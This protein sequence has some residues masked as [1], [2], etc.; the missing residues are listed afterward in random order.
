MRRFWIVPAIVVF[1]LAGAYRPGS[2]S[3]SASGHPHAVAAKKHF[4]QVSAGGNLPGDHTCGLRTDH[5]LACWGNNNHGH[6]PFRLT[7]GV[8]R[9]SHLRNRPPP[10]AP[11]AVP[12]AQPARLRPTI[13]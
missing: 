4:L 13:G 9:S 2:V 7:H 10:I 5:T 12:M 3:V 1:V 11:R 8:A 6:S